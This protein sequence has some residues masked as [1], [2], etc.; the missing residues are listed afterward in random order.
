[1]SSAEYSCKLF[2]PIFAYRQTVWTQIRLLLEEQSDL[3]L[4]CLHKWLLKSQADDKADNN[5]CDWQF[6]GYYGG[7]MSV[8]LYQPEHDKTSNK[9][10]VPAK[11]QVSMYILLVR[12]R[13]LFIPLW[14]AWRLQKIHAINKT[15][16]RLLGCK[17]DLSFCWGMSYCRFYPALACVFFMKKKKNIQTYHQISSLTTS[18]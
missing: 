7:A 16:I 9:T 5:C 15:L 10:F 1:M 14:I 4:H 12:Q 18:L 6:K 11:T 13:F 8:F 2:K 3:G 17:A